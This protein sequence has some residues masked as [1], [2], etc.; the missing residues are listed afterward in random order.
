MADILVRLALRRAV[1]VAF[2]HP[3]IEHEGRIQRRRPAT[4]NGQIVSWFN[5]PFAPGVAASVRGDDAIGRDDV[6]PIDHHLL[7]VGVALG[8]EDEVV[9]LP[10]GSE[11]DAYAPR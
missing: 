10:T 3:A 1:R 2:R 11:R 6:D 9:R 8:V 7:R 4:E 5:A